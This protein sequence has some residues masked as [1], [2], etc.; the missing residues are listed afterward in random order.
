MRRCTRLQQRSSRARTASTSSAK[1]GTNMLRTRIVPRRTMF[2]SVADARAILRI[3]LVC[4]LC[5]RTGQSYRP[6]FLISITF[7][8]FKF[9]L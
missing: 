8:C 7:F 4:L 6:D 3:T 2:G 5:D 1:S 9:R